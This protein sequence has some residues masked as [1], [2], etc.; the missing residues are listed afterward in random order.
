MLRIKFRLFI[1]LLSCRPLSLMY[2]SLYVLRS[3]TLG[4][5]IAGISTLHPD[6][7]L[8]KAYCI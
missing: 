4:R 5:S 6:I 1:R 2:Y 8:V 3:H 7:P